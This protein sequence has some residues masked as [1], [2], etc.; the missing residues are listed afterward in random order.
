MKQHFSSLITYFN[1]PGL[2]NTEQTLQIAK[3]RAVYNKIKRILI[4]S[5]FGHTIQNALNVF[6]GIDIQFI[7]VGGKRS[8]FPEKLF[9]KLVDGNHIVIFNSDYNFQ[10][11]EIVWEI[12]RRFCE[13]MKVCVQMNLMVS[14]LGLLPVGEEVIAVAGTGRE[15]FSIGGGA[16]TA[17]VIETVRSKD[18]FKLDLPQSKSKIIGRKIKEILCKPR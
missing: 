9:E 8:Q 13:G 5:T 6:D 10:Y 2:K 14:D 11:P 7:I 18:F 1:E 3:E 15:D 4:A 12:L 16:D 17:I